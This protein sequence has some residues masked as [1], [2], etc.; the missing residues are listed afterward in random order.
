MNEKWKPIKD[1]EEIYQISNYGRVKNIKTNQ[2][3][4]P[5]DSHGYK[6][7]HLCN[8]NHIRQN[9]AIHRLVALSFI[10]NPYKLPQVNHIDGNKSNNSYSNLEW[11]SNKDNMVHSVKKLHKHCK[12]VKCIET[13][14]IFNSIKEASNFYHRNQNVLVA[15]LRKYKYNHTFAG[16]HWQYVL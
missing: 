6:Y 10:T 12:R 5:I 7:V 8:K 4:K 9:K 2:L 3:L 11:C 13:G 14:Q 1:Y 16:Y 15:V